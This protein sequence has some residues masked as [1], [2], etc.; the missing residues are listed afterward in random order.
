[1]SL[2]CGHKHVKIV[3]NATSAGTY[4]SAKAIRVRHI[5]A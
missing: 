1:M 2:P 4:V 3:C 5:K